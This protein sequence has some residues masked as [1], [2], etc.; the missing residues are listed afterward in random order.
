MLPKVPLKLDRKVKLW[1]Y[2]DLPKLISIFEDRLI[3]FQPPSNFNDPFEGIFHVDSDEEIYEEILKIIS[4]YNKDELEKAFG[5]KIIE[6]W[7][8]VDNFFDGLSKKIP[9]LSLVCC[10]HISESESEAMW[11]IYSESNRGVA[12]TTTVGKLHDI[13]PEGLGDVYPINYIDYEKANK[14]LTR[15]NSIFYKR[16]SFEYE[17]EARA[18]FIDFDQF[19]LLS[20]KKRKIKGKPLHC[21]PENF[22]DQII[23]SPLAEPWYFELIKKIRDRYGYNIPIESP[24]INNVP[25]YLT[26]E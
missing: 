16:K 26:K 4:T 18:F 17:A 14:S 19:N 13:L 20:K 15:Y 22:I 10:W 12:I 3:Y 8:S 23:I 7:G 6:K 5:S 11:Q 24:E 1:R 21:D 25:K 9:E 2:M